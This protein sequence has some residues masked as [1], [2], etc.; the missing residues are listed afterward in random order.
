[1]GAGFVQSVY[2]PCE[3]LLLGIRCPLAMEPTVFNCFDL[4]A[5]L[6]LYSH[7]QLRIHIQII[8]LQ[9]TLQEFKVYGYTIEKPPV[10]FVKIDR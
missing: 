6:Y 2:S 7:L 3:T 10:Q 5:N 8:S 9:D 4:L 1:M